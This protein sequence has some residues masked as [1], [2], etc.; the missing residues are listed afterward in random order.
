[1][2]QTQT[3]SSVLENTNDMRWIQSYEA[4]NVKIV[5]DLSVEYIFVLGNILICNF[6]TDQF[7][8][9]FLVKCLSI[10]VHPTILSV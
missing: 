8:S 4:V 1:M 3:K 7:Y 6:S 10:P 2:R 5:L 9:T